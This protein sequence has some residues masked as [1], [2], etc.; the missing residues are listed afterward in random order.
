M[1]T[2]GVVTVA[3]SDYGIFRPVLEKIQSDP[4]LELFLI[5]AGMHLSPEFGMTVSFIEAVGFPVSERVPVEF[6][7]DTPEGIAES[8]A[9]AVTGFAKCFSKSRPDILLVLGDRYEMHAAVLAALPF[10]IPVAH[11]HGG[12]ITLGAID[13]A[14]RH[15]ITKLSHL[16]FASTQEYADR[17]I[18]MGEEPWRVTV[19]GAPGLDNIKSVEL[20]EKSDLEKEF[21]IVPDP[22]P[23]L[24]TYHPVTL[25]YKQTEQQVGE[26]L[27]AV[28]ES[29]LP[30]VFTSPNSDTGRRTIKRM[31]SEYVKDR[32]NTWLVND[33]G[34]DAYFS[35]MAC[36]AAMVG[37][38]SSGII[39]AASFELPVVNVGSRQ[40]G[41][42]RGKNVIDVDY[43]RKNILEGIR[44]AVS[45]DFR[46]ALK[47]MINPYGKGD[48]SGKIVDVLKR[49]GLDE[50][51]I[52]KR[53]H[54]I[55]RVEDRDG[56]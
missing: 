37:N 29:G 49:T 48:A 54:D 31:I 14:L 42:I 52:K 40:E 56:K 12:E 11:I 23:L 33:F 19:S 51:L 17:I 38:S 24:V 39:E 50:N 10:N 7:S 6:A 2:I 22:A 36:A 45:P 46:A 53:F 8:M 55:G 9:Q 43:E 1:R 30:A 44:S 41:R 21:G 47:G 25:E 15:S 4:E 13:D 27:A 26:L 34:T 18:Q 32:E 35:M 20:L 3:R 5:A 16:H 28:E